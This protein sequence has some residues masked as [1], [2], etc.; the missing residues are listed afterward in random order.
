MDGD[1]GWWLL[2]ACR[3]KKAEVKMERKVRNGRKVLLVSWAK[4]PCFEFLEE[5]IIAGDVG[6]YIH[7]RSLGTFRIVSSSFFSLRMHR[8]TVHGNMRNT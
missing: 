8:F 7:S 1:T 6:C 5:I 2:M 3:G 4:P